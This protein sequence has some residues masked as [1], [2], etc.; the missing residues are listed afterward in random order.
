MHSL[1]FACTQKNF[2]GQSIY[3]APVRVWGISGF[4]L[5]IYF[6]FLDFRD[7]E[8]FIL[9]KGPSEGGAGTFDPTG[10]GTL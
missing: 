3:G 8:L 6:F 1:Y 2:V 10:P 4:I 5:F 7:L 9:D